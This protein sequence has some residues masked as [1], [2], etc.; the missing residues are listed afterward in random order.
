MAIMQ[1]YFLPYIGYFQLIKA[2]DVFVLYDTIEYTKS[3]WINRNRFL[4]NGQAEYM[5]LPLRRASDFALICQRELAESYNSDAEKLLRRIAGAYH[6]APMFDGVFPL[7]ERCLRYPSRNLFAFLFHS[8]KE[9]C[10][11]LDI[12]TPLMAS[13]DVE[14]SVGL[15]GEARVLGLCRDLGATEY[16]NSPGGRSLYDVARFED[17]GV[18]LRFLEPRNQYYNQGLDGHVP[19][20]S[21]LDVLMFNG[22]DCV[23]SM[24]EECNLDG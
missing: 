8:L 7:I 17:A 22:V 16:L 6:E 13:S 11:H 24:L 9:V 3:G 14:S 4:A 5:T 23:A 18:R 10:L 12:T 1:P 15:R 20:L 19:N 21:I 2:S